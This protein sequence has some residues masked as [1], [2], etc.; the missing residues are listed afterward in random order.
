M[1]QNNRKLIEE[2]FKPIMAERARLL[3][4]LRKRAESL[5]REVV[6]YDYNPYLSTEALYEPYVKLI[7]DAKDL[8]LGDFC[9]VETEDIGVM[10]AAKNLRFLATEI[11]GELD[12]SADELKKSKQRIKELEG[13]IKL[14]ISRYRLPRPEN[15]YEISEDILNSFPELAKPYMKEAEACHNFGFYR[16][17]AAMLGNA[18]EVLLNAYFDKKSWKKTK[19]V[20]G[21]VRPLSY[22]D[23]CSMVASKINDEAYNKQFSQLME[24]NSYF[25]GKSNHPSS[26]LFNEHRILVVMQHAIEVNTWMNKN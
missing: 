17:A 11:D 20:G 19:E 6:G 15:T 26:E 7:M 12:S 21:E 5:H 8:G 16:A 2:A 3:K 22:K 9:S 25:R 24:I 4:K 13:E 14:L 10:E 18:F 23:K 1:N